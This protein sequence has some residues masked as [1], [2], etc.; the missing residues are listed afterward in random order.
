MTY[1]A[2]GS[3]PVAS[4][5]PSPG[6]VQAPIYP[7][8]IGNFGGYLFERR[9]PAEGS[10]GVSSYPCRHPGVDVY[11]RRGT[12][13]VAPENGTIVAAAD[14][15]GS[16]WVGYGPWLVVI[17]GNAS[18]KYHLLAHLDPS[19]MSDGPVGKP[20]RAGD[21]VGTVSAANH[22]HWEIRKRMVPDWKLNE[23][24]YNNG[25]DPIA[26]L[27]SSGGVS[28]AMLLLG[29]G[30]TLFALLMYRRRHR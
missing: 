30:M 13:V 7:L 27:K 26:W 11:G 23:N 22:T 9:S 25:I 4:P 21:R 2:L 15:V 1:M 18:G 6:D 20:V 8:V 12:P 29:G 14:G 16:P 19:T 3:T 28:T 17:K 10:C 5:R 24:N